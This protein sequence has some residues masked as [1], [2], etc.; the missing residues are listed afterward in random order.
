MKLTISYHDDTGLIDII[1][2]GGTL[3][4][5]Q[6]EAAALYM[7]LK[8]MLGLRG[9]FLLWRKKRFFKEVDGMTDV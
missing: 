7:T 9:R 3:S 1:T 5:S 8:K 6:T 2:S 4:I